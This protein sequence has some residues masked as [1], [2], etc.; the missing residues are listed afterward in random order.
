MEIEINYLLL[1]VKIEAFIK[2]EYIE[3][4][5]CPKLFPNM[6]TH[7]ECVR[8]GVS[9]LENGTGVQKYLTNYYN[10]SKTREFNN[11]DVLHSDGNHQLPEI[12]EQVVTGQKGSQT[13]KRNH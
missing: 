1:A 7:H 8:S 9:T 5:L 2:W 11:Y 4:V 12:R 3:Y 6:M 10:I 13:T